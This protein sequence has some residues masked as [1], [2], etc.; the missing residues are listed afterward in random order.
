MSV[1]GVDIS[2][3]IGGGEPG[4]DA[5][6]RDIAIAFERAG[7]KFE[8][9]GEF[10]YPKLIPVFEKAMG[11]QFEAEGRGPV[12][13]AW[14]QLSEAYGAWKARKAPGRGLLELS[15]KLREAMT[16]SSS[17]FAERE[18]SARDFNFGTRN[19]P[20]ASFH[21][22]GTSRMPSRAPFDFGPETEEEMN[23]AAASAAREAMKDA[24]LD[25]YLTEEGGT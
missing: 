21:Q 9:F 17:P 18:Y 12:Q 8:R 23:R 6:V 13:G 22:T 25:E 2:Y 19:V 3:Q 5:V 4:D 7:D 14:T 20:Y 10:V 15:G 11:E 24:G 1:F 16:S